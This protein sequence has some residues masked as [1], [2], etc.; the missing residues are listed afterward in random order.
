MRIEGETVILQWQQAT[1]V[2]N[3]VIC[4]S[5][6]GYD[7][8]PRVHL[9]VLVKWLDDR[10]HFGQI[11]CLKDLQDIF[12]TLGTSLVQLQTRGSHK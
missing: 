4:Q 2:I 1:W 5:T 7:V 8:N 12:H 11:N 9:T 6:I 10:I 3:Y